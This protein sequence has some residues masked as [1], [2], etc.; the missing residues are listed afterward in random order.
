[1]MS[2]YECS[3]I[4]LQVLISFVAFGTLVVYYR[5]LKV[6]SRQLNAMQESSRAQSG[7]SLVEFLQSPEVRKAR[8]AVREIL[9]T[10]PFDDWSD[11]ERNYAAL[12]TANYDVAGALIRSGL[13]PIELITA[14]WG[15]SINHCY[16][17]LE[18]FIAEHRNRPGAS[19]RYW[20]NFKWLYEKAKEIE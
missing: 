8:H 11:E 6:M 12:V 9:S 14:N 19:P 13:A 4:I 16:E 5:Q 2:N 1:M 18:P 17:V 15:P 7:L 3:S 20:S 10:K